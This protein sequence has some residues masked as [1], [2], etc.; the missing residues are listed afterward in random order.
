MI[1]GAHLE[2]E[3]LNVAFY[4]DTEQLIDPI[5]VRLIIKK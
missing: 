1:E 4:Q 3:K 2:N 5:K